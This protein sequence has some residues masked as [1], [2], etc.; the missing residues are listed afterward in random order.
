MKWSKK[1]EKR[2]DIQRF[3]SWTDFWKV[4]FSFF[5]FLPKGYI[6]ELLNLVCV[7][8]VRIC[9]CTTCIYIYVFDKFSLKA[10]SLRFFFCSVCKKYNVEKKNACENRA[11]KKSKEVSFALVFLL[12]IKW[13]SFFILFAFGLTLR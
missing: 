11:E 4:K 6:M 10:L 8:Y 13:F 7:Q 3:E 1:G 2:V 9:E 12:E 5:L